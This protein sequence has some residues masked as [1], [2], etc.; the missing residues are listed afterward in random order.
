MPS[1][2]PPGVS[3][4]SPLGQL[5]TQ[6]NALI[7]AGRVADAIE[8]LSEAIELAPN[9]GRLWMGLGVLLLETNEPA[10][11][12]EA[13]EMAIGINPRL[14]VAHWRLGIAL[15]T[16]GERERAIVALEEAVN[17]RPDLADAYIRLALLYAETGRRTD[18]NSAYRRAAEATADPGEKAVL[19]AQACRMEG[20]DEEAETVLRAALYQN[21][22]LPSAHGVLGQ[23]LASAGR[24]DEASQH[25]EL[26]VER[27]PGAG[28]HWYDL[29]RNKKITP[30]DEDILR[31]MDAALEQQPLDDLNRSLLLLARGKVLDDLGRY[32]EAMQSLDEASYL[33]ARA[34]SIDIRAYEKHVDDIVSLFSAEFVAA[35]GCGNDERTPVLIVGMPRSGTTL[36]E[37]IISNHPDAAGAGELAFWIDRLK[38]FLAEGTQAPAQDSLQATATAYLAQLRK[39]SGKARVSDKNPFN[40]LAIGLIHM[41]FPRATIIHSRRNPI[42]AAI[43]IHLTHF[44]RSSGMPTGGEDLVRYFR[45]YRRLMEHWRRVLPEGRLLEVEYERLVTSPHTEIRSIIDHIG[46]PWNASCLT[47]HVNSRL[48]RTPSGWQVRQSINTFSVNRW[49]HYEPWLGPLAALLAPPGQDGTS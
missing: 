18:A 16:L 28:L 5:L 21:P 23:I 43:S 30:A 22:E 9:Y 7:A 10:G 13:L 29:V 15:Q 42:D 45:G 26:Q 4:D 32:Q 33:R 6:V 49:R 3:P 11:A 1:G 31:R 25:F 41:A 14:A 40:F 20:R 34:F 24:F 37:Q 46:L 12:R 39:V 38:D 27:S 36:I 47:P 35:C 19:Q 17:I 44:S 2:L 8:P 48:V